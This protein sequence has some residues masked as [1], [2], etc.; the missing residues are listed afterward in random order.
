MDEHLLA[1][2]KA[3]LDDPDIQAKL[4]HIVRTAQQPPAPASTMPKPQTE[5]PER[6]EQPESPRTS[7]WRLPWGGDDDKSQLKRRVSDLE[8]QVRQAQRDLEDAKRQAGGQVRQAQSEADGYR[9]QL[10]DAKRQL[11][12]TQTEA[13]GYRR[14]AEDANRQIQ[15]VREQCQQTLIAKETELMGTIQSVQD[16]RDSARN[17]QASAE[18]RATAAERELQ[19]LRDEWSGRQRVYDRYLGMSQSLRNSLAGIF[20]GRDLWTFLVSGVQ[21]DSLERFLEVCNATIMKGSTEDVS[22][23][24]ELFDYFFDTI[25]GALSTSPIFS[26]QEV[27]VGDRFDPLQHAA[28]PGSRPSGHITRIL[29]P[30]LV[31]VATGK[32]KRPAIVQVGN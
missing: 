17:A 30:G 15:T 31:Y 4:Q 11:R 27:H 14:Q 12:Q 8:S 18:R 25:N 20:Q 9:R 21:R 16:E 6:E 26:R 23:M 19:G 1:F 2:Y 32:L 3:L 10:E 7:S 29:L 24:N 13:A 28:A 22:A 5:T